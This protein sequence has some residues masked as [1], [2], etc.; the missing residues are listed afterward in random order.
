M[1]VVESTNK[2]LSNRQ[3]AT[4][5][6]DDDLSGFHILGKP[7]VTIGC[8]VGSKPAENDFREVTP[9][10][11]SLEGSNIKALKLPPF[12]VKA[13]PLESLNFEF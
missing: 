6:H 4:E 9:V 8:S 5:M 12:V 7:E 13:T 11:F 3:M 2:R 10:S 1:P